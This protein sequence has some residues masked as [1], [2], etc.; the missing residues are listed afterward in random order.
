MSAEPLQP[1]QVA[2]R[3]YLIAAMQNVG[4]IEV[5]ETVNSATF[6]HEHK[7]WLDKL[8]L[9]SPPM[10]ELYPKIFANITKDTIR[11]LPG[12]YNDKLYKM[13]RRMGDK[14]RAGWCIQDQTNQ[15][16]VPRR[17][18]IPQSF[19]LDRFQGIAT[20]LWEIGH[21]L[22]CE[23]VPQGREIERLSWELRALMLAHRTHISAWRNWF[24]A[25]R[26]IN[27]APINVNQSR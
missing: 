1:H 12:M 5:Q 2:L 19:Q 24:L 17:I 22:N 27:P 10:E 13:F 21:I 8:L 15:C 26:G 7:E 6:V 16:I 4:T 18:P 20:R 3:P 23:E 25:Q 11:V 14:E 9:P